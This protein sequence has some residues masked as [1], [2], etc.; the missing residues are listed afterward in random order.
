MAKINII[1]TMSVRVRDFLAKSAS[2]EVDENS[3]WANR[4]TRNTL[5]LIVLLIIVYAMSTGLP[6]SKLPPRH[7]SINFTSSDLPSDSKG[8]PMSIFASDGANKLDSLQSNELM[9]ALEKEMQSRDAGFTQE[10]IEFDDMKRKQDSEIS[11]LRLD[12]KEMKRQQQVQLENMRKEMQSGAFNNNA[13]SKTT[14]TQSQ[15]GIPNV[16]KLAGTPVGQRYSPQ[17]NN[18][19][20]GQPVSTER[21][22]QPPEPISAAGRNQGGMRVMNGHGSQRITQGN[23]QEINKEPVQDDVYVLLDKK[24]AELQ[25]KRAMEQDERELVEKIEYEKTVKRNNIIQLPAGTVLSGTLINGMQVPTGSSSQS[26][27]M[28]ALF[29][30]KRE[31]I[32]P[33]YFRVDEVVECV[34][35]A[36]SRPSIESL[37]VIFRSEAIS[38]IRDDGRVI[39]VPL[40]AVSTGADGQ[41]GVSAK[42]VSR[43]T[44]LLMQTATAGFLQGLTDIFSQTSLEVNSDDGVYAVGG[45]ELA[46]LTGSAAL[47]GAGTALEKLADYY[48]SLAEKMQ[49]TLLVLPGIAVDFNVT[50]I[51]KLDFNIKEDDAKRQTKIVPS[52]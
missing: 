16:D 17:I 5:L 11:G 31:A 12:L 21:Y 1:E 43:N 10:K 46:K 28:P 22:L 6:E 27:P 2:K 51:S 48:M 34:L 24:K 13:N 30:I 44:D 18:H 29:R 4:K 37:R 39:E 33:N 9:N 38:C 42:L 41:I 36:S 25:L 50:T 52:K 49:P 35:V 20:N 7:N 23:I 14:Q 32:L 47:G 3:F 15:N 8:K 19:V 40:K 26:D 45:S